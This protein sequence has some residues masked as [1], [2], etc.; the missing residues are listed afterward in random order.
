MKLAEHGSRTRGSPV[1]A[2]CMGLSLGFIAERAAGCFSLSCVGR[3][4][5]EGSHGG[6]QTIWGSQKNS[7]RSHCR[8]RLDRRCAERRFGNLF[9][10][11]FSEPSALPR[12]RRV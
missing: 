1:A 7:G 9:A 8:E 12:G 11:A 10:P 3:W 2:V 4:I 6:Q 5:C